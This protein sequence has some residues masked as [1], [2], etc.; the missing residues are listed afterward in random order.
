MSNASTAFSRRVIS[1]TVLYL[2]TS[3]VIFK[4][5]HSWHSVSCTKGN[6]HWESQTAI[7]KLLQKRHSFF[8]WEK[9]QLPLPGAQYSVFYALFCP[10][11]KVLVFICLFV[12]GEQGENV[13]NVIVPIVCS[14]KH[15]SEKKKKSLSHYLTYLQLSNLHV[16]R[17][18]ISGNTSIQ[19]QNN[20]LP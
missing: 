4:H 8:S 1:F 13:S 15:I 5:R 17:L 9:D 10:S 20:S 16:L 6:R 7:L 12:W 18:C 11:P 2:P 14:K 3:P 19:V